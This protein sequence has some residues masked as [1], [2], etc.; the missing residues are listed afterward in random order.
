ML[1]LKLWDVKYGNAAYIK[2]PNGKNIVQDLGV[3]ALKT[4]SLTFSPLLFL[5]NSM[6]IDHLDEV[7]LT[8]PHADHI[9][10]IFNFD[11]FTPEVLNRSKG[12]TRKEILDANRDEDRKLVEKYIEI[13]NRYNEDI[14]GRESPLHIEN[15]GGA[16]IQVF[17]SLRRMGSNINNDG[18]VTVINYAT[19]KIFLPGDNDKESIKELL[20]QS[21]FE[22]AIRDTDIF[23]APHHG[24]ESGFC[25]DLFNYFRPKLVIVSS[26]RF[27]DNSCLARYNEIASGW[28]V[29][30]RSGG[31]VERKYLITKNDGIIEIAMGWIIEGKKSFLSITAD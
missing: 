27:N 3:G 30:T 22:E 24:L 28:N 13:S 18:V 4:N 12:L 16:S 8:H 31:I 2:T 21:S 9:K 1:Y 15:N 7:I 14:S 25:G 5:K 19:S 26:S 11:S 17:Q 29:H 10:D 20:E 23:V 6:N